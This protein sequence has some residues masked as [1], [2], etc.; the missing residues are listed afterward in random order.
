MRSLI[1]GA[2]MRSQFHQCR[3]RHQ[4]VQDGG[5]QTPWPWVTVGQFEWESMKWVHCYDK[6][7]L[8]E[9]TG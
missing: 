3:N 5:R 6:N 9:A 7:R 4:T 2:K 8:L 1:A